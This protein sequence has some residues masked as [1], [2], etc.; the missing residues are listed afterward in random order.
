M[1]LEDIAKEYKAACMLVPDFVHD[2]GLKQSRFYNQL[3]LSRNA[4]AVR[5][6]NN[7]WSP[8]QLEKIGQLLA[9]IN[10][11]KNKNAPITFIPKN[12]LQEE[13]QRENAKAVGQIFPITE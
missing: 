3:G 1:I 13:I 5:L 8:D 4:F 6:R 12:L 7:N 10:T 9:S 2:S 11:S